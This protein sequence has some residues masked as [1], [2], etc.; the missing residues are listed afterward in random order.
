MRETHCLLCYE[1]LEIRDVAPCEICGGHPVSVE[2]F[3]SGE[4][5]Y[6]EYVVFGLNLVLCKPCALDFELGSYDPDFF[7]L[8]AQ[9]QVDYRDMRYLR[10]LQA[11]KIE[12]DKYCPSCNCRLAFLRFVSRA[13][14]VNT[15]R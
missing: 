2:Q 11:P 15:K 12:K 9:T 7:G 5:T 1:P 8:H 6:T 13:R 3:H 4:H 10:E 14:D